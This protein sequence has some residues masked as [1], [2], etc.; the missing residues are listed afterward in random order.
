MLKI[1]V[2]ARLYSPPKYRVLLQVHVDVGE[3][4][5]LLAARGVYS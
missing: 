4:E 5:S 2:V 1:K 3:I